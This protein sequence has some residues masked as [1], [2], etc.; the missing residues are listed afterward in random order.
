MKHLPARTAVLVAVLTALLTLA[1]AAGA[2]DY[3]LQRGDTLQIEVLEDDSLNRSALILPD[4]QIALPTLGSLPAAGRTLEEVRADIAGRL[5]RDF[6][7][8]P[9]VY[10]TMGALH[11]PVPRAE[12]SIDI[13]ILGAANAPGRVQVPAGS[14]L[15]QAVAAAGGLSPFAAPARLQL[16][17]IDP[18]GTERIY[19]I[20]F[21][22]ITAGTSSQ[23]TLRVTD[24]DVIVVPQRRLFE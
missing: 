20:D 2:Q 5:S 3:R 6:A 21:A 9:T 14:T 10:V 4:G 17:R 24:G 22:A 18:A 7:T 15:L 8:P 23:G 16:R 19:R 1:G 11:V 12:R 13:F